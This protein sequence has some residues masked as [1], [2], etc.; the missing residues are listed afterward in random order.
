M[1]NEVFKSITDW[2]ENGAMDI[3]TPP[4]LQKYQSLVG[5]GTNLWVRQGGADAEAAAGVEELASEMVEHI[6][7]IASPG[8]WK[9]RD[10]C[11]VRTASYMSPLHHNESLSHPIL[12]GRW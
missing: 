7:E 6:R 3:H 5:G 10:W 9:V 4:I 11:T 8:P 12:R 1:D 2:S